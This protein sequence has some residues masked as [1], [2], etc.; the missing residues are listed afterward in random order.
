MRATCPILAVFVIISMILATAPG[1]KDIFLDACCNGDFLSF[2]SQIQTAF[3][4][5]IEHRQHLIVESLLPCLPVGA[6]LGEDLSPIG[7]AIQVGDHELAS[8]VLG[9]RHIQKPAQAARLANMAAQKEFP[10]S[11][12]LKLMSSSCCSS[13]TLF[14]ACEH[15]QIDLVMFLGHH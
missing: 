10:L 12:I 4:S 14:A 1:E 7:L 5:A 9:N 3:M 15:N 13:K 8:L 6:L 2:S 11:I